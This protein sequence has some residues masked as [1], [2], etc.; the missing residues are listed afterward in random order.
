MGRPP[1]VGTCLC[2]PYSHQTDLEPL[3][4]QPEWD[5]LFLPPGRA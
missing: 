5:L 3:E 1:S 4:T 2:W